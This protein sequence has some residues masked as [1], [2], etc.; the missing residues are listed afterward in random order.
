MSMDL[1]T[2]YKQPQFRNEMTMMLAGIPWH[3]LQHYVMHPIFGKWALQRACYNLQ[4]CFACFG[5]QEQ[6]E[7]SLQ[8]FAYMFNW[9]IIPEDVRMKQTRARPLL[10]EVSPAVYKK[11]AELNELDMLLYRFAR[12]LFNR[13]VCQL[14]L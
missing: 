10:E 2:F 6:F 7:K 3:K 9:K 5:L 11:L 4:H 8:L 1:L 13:R 14:H 12:R